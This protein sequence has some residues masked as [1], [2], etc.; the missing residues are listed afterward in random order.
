MLL[1]ADIG[2]SR[3]KVSLFEND[4]NPLFFVSILHDKDELINVLLDIKNENKKIDSIFYASVKKKSNLLFEEATLEVFNIKP[5][6]ITHKDV[7]LKKNYYK[8]EDSI[9]IDRLLASFASII[10]FDDY[11]END[12]ASIVLS[13]GTATTLSVMTSKFEFLG[14]MII[15][16]IETS[17]LGL[18]KQTS[19]PNVDLN[20]VSKYKSAI[21]ND[22]VSALSAGIYYQ[23]IGALNFALEDCKK[24]IKEKYNLKSRVTITGGLLFI[25][26]FDCKPN[27]YLV[28]QGIYFC[29]KNM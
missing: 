21:N 1:I 17:F 18:T 16:G 20:N 7:N 5:Y 6:E 11:K 23:T 9:G 12:F 26:I 4:S 22:T 24:E 13:M 8:P 10:L 27:I 29:V 15:P 28:L 14:G 3:I 25:D 2:N 19:L